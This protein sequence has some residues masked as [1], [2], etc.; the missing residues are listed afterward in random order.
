MRILWIRVTM[1]YSPSYSTDPAAIL[2]V[3]DE[4][5]PPEFESLGFTAFVKLQTIERKITDF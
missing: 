1:I 5:S 3:A 4:V 2:E